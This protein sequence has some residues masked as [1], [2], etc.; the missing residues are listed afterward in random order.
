MKHLKYLLI[1][2]TFLICSNSISGISFSGTITHNL[3]N[4]L[5]INSDQASNNRSQTIQEFVR[6]GRDYLRSQQPSLHAKQPQYIL[7][8]PEI[9][10]Q[11]NSQTP[12]GQVPIDQEQKSQRKTTE[13][14]LILRQA[15]LEK[16]R[17][18]KELKAKE[19]KKKVWLY[20]QA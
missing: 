14:E 19:K 8:T 9:I 18:L 12:S 6:Q 4:D 20:H 3:Q 13:Q 15:Q 17:K 1:S 5:G 16:E 7:L 2:L 10:N 11:I